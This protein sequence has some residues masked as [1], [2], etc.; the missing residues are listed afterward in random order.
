MSPLVTKRKKVNK[1]IAGLPLLFLSLPAIVYLILFHYLPI[2]GIVVA[3]KE[4]NYSDGIINS[5][6]IGLDNFKFFFQSNDAIRVIFNTIGY[7]LWFNLI[8]TVFAIVVALLLFEVTNK[9]CLK[10]FQTTIA[11]PSMISWVILTYI[12]YAVLN[13][14]S[15]IANTF[16]TS[17]GLDKISWYSSPGYWP[18][19][20]TVVKVWQGVGMS[21]VI[22]Y[23]ALMGVDESLFEAAKLDG[24]NRL[25]QIR[26]I[27]L[28]AI[29]PVICIMTILAMAHIM[30]GDIG[31]F[32][33]V[34]RDSVSLYPVTDIIN[35][36]IL[37]GLKTGS[38]GVSAAVGLFQN[39]VGCVML[40][41]TNALVKK[42]SPDNS[43]F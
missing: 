28:P 11:I 29:T 7:S 18:F 30:S 31:V 15:G 14:D 3:F 37:K 36:Y 16:L 5:P 34:P 22:Y 6:W 38:M 19:I 27:S 23:A 10:F 12:V 33:Q 4:F 1:Y 24:A 9:K 40:L 42:I 25:Q 13:F 26:Y 17:I 39:V 43:M 20:L 8:G 41:V 21:C 35:T 2:F 32:F